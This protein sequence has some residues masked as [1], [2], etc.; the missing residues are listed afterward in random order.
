MTAAPLAGLPCASAGGLHAVPGMCE[1]IAAFDWSTTP[2]GSREDWPVELRLVVEQMLL[3]L[4][5]I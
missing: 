2:L 3:S 5:H 4:I 1:Q